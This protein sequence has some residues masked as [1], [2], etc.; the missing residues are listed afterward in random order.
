MLPGIGIILGFYVAGHSAC[1]LADAKDEHVR[2]LLFLSFLTLGLVV[3]A[4]ILKGLTLPSGQEAGAF[5]DLAL[6]SS[7]HLAGAS[8][9]V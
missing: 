9:P 6:K 4:L 5:H 3:L 2:L 1:L 8:R 7:F